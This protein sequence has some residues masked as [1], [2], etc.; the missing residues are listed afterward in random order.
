MKL[1]VRPSMRM[2]LIQFPLLFFKISNSGP[3]WKQTIVCL[4][5]DFIQKHGMYFSSFQ[6]PAGQMF[7]IH[8]F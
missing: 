2:A 1:G 6:W 3:Q 8:V 7:P 5:D 4:Y